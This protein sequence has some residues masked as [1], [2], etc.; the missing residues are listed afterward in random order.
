MKSYL[1]RI[2]HPF[3][4]VFLCIILYGI[5]L[6]VM[7]QKKEQDTTSFIHA[8]SKFVNENQLSYPLKVLPDSYGYDGQFYYRLSQNPFTDQRID[9]GIALDNPQYRQQRILY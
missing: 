7:L 6:N 9:S 8:G 5:F 3:L 1:H 2:N 4:P